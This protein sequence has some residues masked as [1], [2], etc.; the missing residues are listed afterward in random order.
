M[1]ERRTENPCVPSSILGLGNWEYYRAENFT[2]YL[3][4]ANSNGALRPRK[5]VLSRVEGI[6]G[7]GTIVSTQGNIGA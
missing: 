5:P 2:P 3:S 6:L 4:E 1:V 7:L